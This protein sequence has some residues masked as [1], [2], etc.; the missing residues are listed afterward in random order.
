MRFIDF[1][2]TTVLTSA[3]GA[4]ALGVLT[5]ARAGGDGDTALFF[6]ALGWWVVAGGIGAYVGRRR[7]PLPAIRRLLTGARAT[8]S[9]PE[10]RPVAVLL[11]RLWP[12]LVVLVGAGVLGLVAPQVPAIAAG[13]AAIWALYWRH[14]DAAVTAIEDRDGIA[15]F[16]ERTKV[17]RPMQLVRTPSFHRVVP[18]TMNGAGA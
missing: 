5:I 17:M 8:T 16:I 11:N 7:E 18:H 14:Q 12:L 13:F 15:F 9:L 1:L 4:T 2:K 3:A 10:Q 6:F